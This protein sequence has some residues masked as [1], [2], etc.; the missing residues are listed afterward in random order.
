MDFSSLG[1]L[2]EG[3]GPVQANLI[4]H[5]RFGASFVGISCGV[6]SGTGDASGFATGSFLPPQAKVI[7]RFLGATS[8]AEGDFG[9]TLM[10]S[11]TTG[12]LRWT[13]AAGGTAGAG[14]CM[15]FVDSEKGAKLVNIVFGGGGLGVLVREGLVNPSLVSSAVD[16][17]LALLI[18]DRRRDRSV[19]TCTSG[20]E[21]GWSGVFSAFVRSDSF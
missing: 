21:V 10:R 7:H 13:F 12:S 18:T 14:G 19:F 17:K 3:F 5:A 6:G 20:F 4:V 1:D 2:S 16:A 9:D 8:A 15:D 11:A